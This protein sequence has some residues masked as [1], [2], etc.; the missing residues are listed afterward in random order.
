MCQQ[1]HLAE[2]RTVLHRLTPRYP[3]GVPRAKLH[4]EME[5]IGITDT[6]PVI[7]AL[8]ARGD[9]REPAEGRYTLTTGTTSTTNLAGERFLDL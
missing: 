4:E 8:V 3:D 5:R 6:E 1:A 9:I 2:V 7:S